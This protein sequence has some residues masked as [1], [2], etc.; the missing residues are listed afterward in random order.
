MCA[1]ETLV[2]SLH[3]AKNINNCKMLGLPYVKATNAMHGSSGTDVSASLSRFSSQV[4]RL[5]LP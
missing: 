4:Y 2:S 5:G 3:A 1:D